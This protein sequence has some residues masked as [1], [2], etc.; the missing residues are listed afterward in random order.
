MLSTDNPGG[1]EL[2]DLFEEDVTIV[3]REDAPALSRAAVAFLND[4]RRTSAAT[5]ECIERDLRPERVYQRFREVYERLLV[6]RAVK[7]QAIR[8]PSGR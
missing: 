2:K 1:L 7:S 4:T 3:P 6:D 5:R 8:R